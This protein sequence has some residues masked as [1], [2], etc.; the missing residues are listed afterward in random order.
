MGRKRQKRER[1]IREILALP[2][3]DQEERLADQHIARES[4]RIRADWPEGER[5]ARA[6]LPRRVPRVF[7]Q[8]ASV[9]DLQGI[10]AAS[11]REI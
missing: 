7:M 4:A 1:T 3:T 2:R 8:I 9:D 11:G 5:R 10:E 6:G